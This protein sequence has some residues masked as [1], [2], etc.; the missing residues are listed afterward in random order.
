M[1]LL[2]RQQNQ[3]LILNKT[4]IARHNKTRLGVKSVIRL[5]LSVR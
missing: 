1:G 3:H 2:I 4:R 5:Q